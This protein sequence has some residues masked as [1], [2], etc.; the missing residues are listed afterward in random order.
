MN[1][2]D[3]LRMCIQSEDGKILYLLALI[4]ITM[5]IDFITGTIGAWVSEDIEFRSKEG[6]NG[7]LRKIASMLALLIFVPVSVLI[8][9]DAGVALMYTLYIGYLVFELKSILENLNRC[10]IE[11][12]LFEGIIDALKK[13]GK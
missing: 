11:V 6:I 4:A 2:M 12:K 8:P 10:G 7:I 13:G 5:I 9:N 3:F 1:M